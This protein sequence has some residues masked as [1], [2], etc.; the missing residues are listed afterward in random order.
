MT[1]HGCCNRLTFFGRITPPSSYSRSNTSI[2][3]PSMSDG[4]HSA[5][6][7]CSGSVGAMLMRAD[8]RGLHCEPDAAMY[9]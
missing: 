1:T 3:C 4:G 5:P 2:A 9:G 6:V 8:S 7:L